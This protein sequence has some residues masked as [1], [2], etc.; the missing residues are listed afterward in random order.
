M[1]TD[2]TLPA[3]NTQGMTGRALMAMVVV[4]AMALCLARPVTA[5]SLLD[6]P[7]AGGRM[8]VANTGY[9]TATFLGSDA[10]YFNTLFLDGEAADVRLFD[11]HSEVGTTIN[12]GT[13]TAG[14]ELVFRLDVRNTGNRFFTGDAARNVDGIAHALAVTT[15]EQQTYVTTVGFEDLLNGG[16]LDYNDFT[17]VLHNVIDPPAVPSPSA[18]ALLG[19]G[20][21]LL[22]WS[23]HRRSL[24]R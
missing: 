15:L 8:L 20:I 14:T 13:F 19:L 22:G 18:L 10:G 7:I 2:H 16:D 23:L 17:F 9:V 1:S 11:K 5:G 3:Q 24:R 6:V 4:I 21:G 12:L